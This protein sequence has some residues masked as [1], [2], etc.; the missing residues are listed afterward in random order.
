MKFIE[1]SKGYRTMVDDEDY[2]KLSLF[3][4][5]AHEVRG[6]D[7]VYACR[8]VWDGKRNHT[9]FMHRELIETAAGFYTDHRDGDG[10]NNQRYNLRTATRGQNTQNSAKKAK[11]ASKYK[12]V[13]FQVCK[14]PWIARIQHNNSSIYLGMFE[15]EIKA[16]EAYNAAAVTLFGEFARLNEIEESLAA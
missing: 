7:K 1:L 12:G 13:S 9:V 3:K 6:G 15:T 14:K 8:S 16:A 5:N 10:L 2:D 11:A 4:W